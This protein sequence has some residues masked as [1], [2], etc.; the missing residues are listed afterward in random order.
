MFHSLFSSDI[1]SEL[2]R[3][4]RELQQSFVTGSSIRGL[5]RGGF[6]AM[7]VGTTPETVEVFAYA[8][9]LDPASID[10][11]VERGTLSIS[12]ERSIESQH[13][14]DGEA[15]EGKRTRHISERFAGRFR[16]VVSLPDDID[17]DGV[18]ASYTDG[19]LRV[20]IKRARESQPRRITV[21]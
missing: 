7:N 19:V 14:G 16:R 2:D 21:Q 17:A 4:Q 9:G 18:S 20:S 13:N 3:I 15:E 6:P 5:G 8:P 12:G 11:Q 10:A 1:F